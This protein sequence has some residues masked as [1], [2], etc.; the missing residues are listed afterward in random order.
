MYLPGGGGGGGS[1][2]APPARTPM[3]FRLECS[4][5]N[6][7]FHGSLSERLVVGIKKLYTAVST[8]AVPQKRKSV[9]DNA[10]WYYG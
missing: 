9:R 2:P 10:D 7:R 5:L 8:K 1:P 4:L 3:V 6:K